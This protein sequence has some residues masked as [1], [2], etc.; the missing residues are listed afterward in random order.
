M[1]SQ[2]TWLLHLLQNTN[3]LLQIDVKD[4]FDPWN[5]SNH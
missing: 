4:A 2:A 5:D 3:L 1:Y